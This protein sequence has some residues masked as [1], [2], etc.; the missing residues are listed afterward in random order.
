MTTDGRTV[1]IP[2]EAVGGFALLRR[3]QRGWLRPDLVAG[4]TVGAMLVPQSMAYAE[5]AGV[6]AATGLYASLL[7][8]VAY[9]LTGTSR[10]LGT[11]P[12]PGT[13]IL[14]ATGVAAV[15]GAGVAG[16]RYL[17]LMATLA[18]LVAAI[19]GIA[20]VLRLGAL[21]QLLSKPVLV[22]YITGV[23]MVL[24][25][26]QLTAFT[27]VPIEADTFFPRVVEF[28][29]ALD[30]IR[31]T[32]LVLALGSLTLLLALRRWAP[33]LPGA[34]VAVALATVITVALDLAARG[35][36]TI[37]TIPAGLPGFV[38]P[39]VAVT[40]VVALLPVALGVALVGYSDNVLTARAV[41]TKMGYRIDPNR[42]LAALAS[43][44]LGAGVLQGMPVS[45][46]ASRSAVPASLGSVTSLVGIVA[47][48]VVAATLLVAGDVL[49]EVPRAAL[50]AIIVAAAFAIIDVQGLRELWRISRSEALLALATSLTVMIVDV[51][52]GVLVAIGLSIAI[53]LS[54]L[55]RPADAVLGA[56][57]DLD[58]WVSVADPVS[59]TLPGLLVF[60]FDA[61]LFFLNVERFRSR[62]L[63]VLD[64][65]PG[66][67]SWVVLDLEGV[68]DVDASAIDGV[69]ELLEQLEGDGVQT[70]AIARANAHALARLTRAELLAPAGPVRV[71]PTINAAVAAYRAQQG[72]AQP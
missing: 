10:H 30:A 4:L 51:L 49:A 20:W 58:G 67:E 13:A 33:K 53:A 36:P 68:S 50:A 31:P 70:V 55:A 28:A 57:D 2:R 34:L 23:G 3:Y 41:A 63:Q 16:E 7:A 1:G 17:A 40:D 14:A 47:A 27:G 21:A 42:E 39:G 43:A 60:R 38:L 64:E 35:E 46:S 44:N 9:A 24:L 29:R 59:R 18:L 6:P 5:L 66:E 37:G 65:N 56:R 69:R 54:R 32:T 48:G 11:G 19:A 71:F 12:E 62:V 22:G 72:Q 45:S 25:S 61:P 26:S 15:A 8:P 52:V